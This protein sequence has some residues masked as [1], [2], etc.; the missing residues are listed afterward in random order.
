[1][2]IRTTTTTNSKVKK[3]QFPNNFEIG[4]FINLLCKSREDGKW[5]SDKKHFDVHVYDFQ[6]ENGVL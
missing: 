2:N 5:D 4:K 6:T 1:M 3:L